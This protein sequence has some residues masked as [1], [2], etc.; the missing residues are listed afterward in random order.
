MA[1][2]NCRSNNQAMFIA[3]LTLTHHGIENARQSPVYICQDTLICV[4]C[5]NIEFQ[6]PANELEKLRL[7]MADP[8]GRN[9]SVKDS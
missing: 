2:K 8:T 7:G 5:G 1:C 9:H 6:V 3:E 4:D